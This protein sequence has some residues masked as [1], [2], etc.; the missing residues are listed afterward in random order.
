MLRLLKQTRA[1][2]SM[3]NADEVRRRAEQPLHIGL[4][5]DSSTAYAEM[6]DFLAPQYLP[7]EER[8]ERL[9]QVHRATDQE[10]PSQVD[11]VLYE[12][13]LACPAR[14]FSY[15]RDN[16]QRTIEEILADKRDLPLAL[17]RQ[18]PAFRRT[19]IEDVIH[20]V[21]RENAFFSIVTAL[22]NV[23]PNLIELPWIFGEFAS[24][25]AFLTAN[26][27]R[28]AFQIAAAC[29]KKTG[30]AEQ[31][32]E[33]LGIAGGAFGWRALARELAGH[34]PL[35][36]GLIPKGA[37][38]Y[39]GTYLTGK[40]LEA[41]NLQNPRHSAEERKLLYQRGLER[42]HEVARSLRPAASSQN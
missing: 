30:L 24:D 13:G 22:P 6:E 7:R 32:F 37:I 29:G 40:G 21:A 9:G 39:A 1:A 38:A 42:G 25:T 41:L 35:G 34:I 5:A 26:Q 4:V 23:I 11:I 17:A 14:A 8:L 36:G 12:P 31:K 33:V 10:P 18:F 27:V 2:F 15:H 3:L 28:M 20:E 19:V 16:P